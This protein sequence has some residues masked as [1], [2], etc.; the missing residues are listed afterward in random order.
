M[1][2]SASPQR[3]AWA[4]RCRALRPEPQTL[5]KVMAGTA[6]GRPARRAAWRAGFCPEPAVS[7]WPRITS[8]TCSPERPVWASS[9]RI[10]AAPSC[11]AGMLAREPWMLPMAVRVAATITTSCMGTPNPMWGAVI[12]HY[13][14][15]PM[16]DDPPQ[17]GGPGRAEVGIPSHGGGGIRDGWGD[18]RDSRR[19]IV[20]VAHR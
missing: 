17:M 7:T 6:W 18:H 11:G 4:A 1:I 9:W 3:I 13:A 10:T 16:A 8:S 2:T 19:V 15:A 14:P 20:R 12:A 5:F